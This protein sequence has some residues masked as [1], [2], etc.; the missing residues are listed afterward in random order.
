M[1]KGFTLI[2][3]M[4][5]ITI[6]GLLATILIANVN[7]ARERGRDAK[8]VADIHQIQTALHLYGANLRPEAYPVGDDAAAL[9]N[10]V[11]AGY[12]AVIP[13]DPS[14]ASYQYKGV[15]SCGMTCNA[16]HLGASLELTNTFNPVL[17]GDKDC[18]PGDGCFVG[19]ETNITGDDGAGCMGETSLHCYDIS[20]L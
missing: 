13:K 15:S 5:V 3:L 7:T 11:S 17:N 1:K 6:I 9:N 8:R 10:L 19:I 4:V 20:N 18:D 14:G 12:M 16:Y 2:E